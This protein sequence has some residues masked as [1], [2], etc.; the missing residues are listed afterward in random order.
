MNDLHAYRRPQI[1]LLGSAIELL[2]GTLIKGRRGV[3][4]AVHWHI[5]PVYDLDE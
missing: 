5:I 2:R 4:E 1:V 3:I